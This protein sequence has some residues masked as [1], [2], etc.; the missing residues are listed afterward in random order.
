MITGVCTPSLAAPLTRQQGTRMHH[1]GVTVLSS[2]AFSSRRNRT[3]AMEE[4]RKS[5]KSLSTQ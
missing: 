2:L 1:P 3:K 4:R 5:L